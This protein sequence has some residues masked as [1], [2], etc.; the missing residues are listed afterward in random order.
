MA[1]CVSCL[2]NTGGFVIKNCKG[3]NHHIYCVEC[4]SK[5]LVCNICGFIVF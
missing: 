4:H 5:I 2:K 3:E 1:T